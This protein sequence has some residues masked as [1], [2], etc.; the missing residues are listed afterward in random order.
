MSNLNPNMFLGTVTRTWEAYGNKEFIFYQHLE[1]FDKA[2]EKL[3]E[4]IALSTIQ[5]PS[6]MR[7]VATTEF[8][9]Y[10]LKS[11][12]K[13]RIKMEKY[14]DENDVKFKNRLDEVIDI[15]TGGNYQKIGLKEYTKILFNIGLIYERLGYSRA[16]RERIR[17]PMQ[18]D[19]QLPGTQMPE[20][21][22]MPPNMGDNIPK[23]AE[24]DEG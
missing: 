11:V 5:S 12:L 20:E 7:V 4:L 23:Y 9:T 15:I 14:K 21:M 8:L 13:V 16:E 2:Q 18:S 6:P 19:I 22:E 3:S 24:E 1:P 10:F 17:T